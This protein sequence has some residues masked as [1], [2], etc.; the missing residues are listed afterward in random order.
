MVWMVAPLDPRKLSVALLPQFKLYENDQIPA[1][2]RL[3]DM[4]CP[5]RPP[6]PA[7]CASYV[8]HTSQQE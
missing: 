1:I 5:I 8:L 3:L 7:T 4:H 2:I 6:L